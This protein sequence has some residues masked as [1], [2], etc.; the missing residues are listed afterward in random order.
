MPKPTQEVTSTQEWNQKFL[1]P[2]P[3]LMPPNN[4]SRTLQSLS[5]R[6]DRKL[7]MKVWASEILL[8]GRMFLKMLLEN[9]DCS[10]LLPLLP[11]AMLLTSR[12]HP[13]YFLSYLWAGEGRSHSKGGACVF[14]LGKAAYVHLFQGRIM[15]GAYKLIT[16]YTSE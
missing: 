11:F 12:F 10:F 6:V 5:F 3:L 16:S 7:F 2:F 9:K 8:K 15:V 1:I 14:V 13:L 4:L